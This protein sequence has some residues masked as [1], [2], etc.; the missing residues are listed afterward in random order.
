[1]AIAKATGDAEKIKEEIM[2]HVE[3]LL[4]K[5]SPELRAWLNEQK[6]KTAEELGN[7]HWFSLEKGHLLG[8][9]MNQPVKSMGK[10]KH[11][12][13]RQMIVCLKENRIK[14]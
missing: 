8:A 11:Q 2:I 7:L 3:Q 14:T 10:R 6:P 12:T 1:M 4:D 5:V 13:M 9:S